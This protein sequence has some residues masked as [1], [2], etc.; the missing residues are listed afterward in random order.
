MDD[1]RET[2]MHPLDYLLILRRRLRWLVIPAVTVLVLGVAVTF[3]LPSKYRSGVTLAIAGGSL[4][5]DL[6]HPIDREERVR[7]L[8]QHLLDPQILG[9]VARLEHLT[10]GAPSQ[11]DLL[12]LRS[13]IQVSLPEPVPG[14][15]P[16][17]VD[18]YIVSYSDSTAEQARR[19]AQR[20]ADVFVEA[21]SRSRQER[22]ENTSEFLANQMRE[23]KDRLDGIDSRLTAAKAK[24]MGRLPEQTN[25]NLQIVQSLQQQLSSASTQLRGEQDRLDTINRTISL[26]EQQS[27]DPSGT[28]APTNAQ[29]RVRQIEQDLAAARLRYTEKNPEVQDL[30]AELDRAKKDAAAERNMPLADK[31]A[32][33]SENPA[34]RQAIGERDATKLRI[35]DF[36]RVLAQYNAQI[37]AYQGRLEGAPLIEQEISNLTQERNLV[38]KQYDDLSQ[39]LQAA[40]LQ[41]DSER[42]RGSEHFQVLYPATLPD[43]PYEPNRQR[44]LLLTVAASLFLG[45]GGA[46]GREYLDQ[47]I[48]DARTLQQEFD[49]PVLGEIPHIHKAA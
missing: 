7:A 36:E 20:L 38:Q 6:T 12:G 27:D 9:R 40:R 13:R 5:A 31:Q 32:V 49:L 14:V 10:P 48:H 34:Y 15:D 1:I 25:A 28:Q 47:S 43:A 8:T 23:T 46:V 44:L 42:K 45:I 4:S 19:V 11:G 30:L 35:R 33:L 2:R 17:Q 16:T 37:R 29:Q 3:L 22:Q 18:V 21:T 41:E 39:K 26:L 24:N